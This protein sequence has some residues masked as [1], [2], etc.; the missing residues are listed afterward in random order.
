MYLTRNKFLSKNASQKYFSDYGPKKFTSTFSYFPFSAIKITKN[1][2]KIKEKVNNFKENEEHCLSLIDLGIIYDIRQKEKKLINYKVKESS[3]RSKKNINNNKVKESIKSFISNKGQNNRFYSVNSVDLNSRNYFPLINRKKRKTNTINLLKNNIKNKLKLNEMFFENKNDKKSS[4]RNSL[5][6]REKFRESSYKNENKK[7]LLSSFNLKSSFMIDKSD[8]DQTNSKL[9]L[10]ELINTNKSNKSNNS[11][12]YY[13]LN[14]KLTINNYF[15]FKSNKNEIH[16]SKRKIINIKRNFKKS[17]SYFSATNIMYPK[18]LIT[19]KLLQKNIPNR[20]LSS[21][22]SPIILKNNLNI[23]NESIINKNKTNLFL[24]TNKEANMPKDNSSY[25]SSIS[26]SKT[27]S[28]VNILKLNTSTNELSKKLKMENSYSLKKRKKIFRNIIKNKIEELEKEYKKDMEENNYNDMI[29]NLVI[30]YMIKKC[31]KTLNLADEKVN[32]EIYTMM[33]KFKTDGLDKNIGHNLPDIFSLIIKIRNQ[34]LIN[35]K[36]KSNKKVKAQDIIKNIEIMYSLIEKNNYLRN[37][38]DK[39]I[40][41]SL[42]NK[43]N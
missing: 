17:K 24:T 11:N 27:S 29:N 15:S 37:K 10:T 25:S 20:T 32:H 4:K 13:D 22:K 35:E 42:E 30:N 5:I 12:N 39:F 33:S 1:K 18:N 16:N 7:Y 23:K 36:N 28:N 34:I 31:K 21:F 3:F 40:G 2:F 41:L 19:N 26:K 14:N 8:N 38:I 6:Y 9:L 43:D